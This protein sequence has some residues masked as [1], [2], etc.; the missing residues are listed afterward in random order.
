MHSHARTTMS[1]DEK[2]TVGPSLPAVAL[3]P[4]AIR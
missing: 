4:S 3:E 1:S 2:A